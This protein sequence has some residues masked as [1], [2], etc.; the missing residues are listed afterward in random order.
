MKKSCVVLLILSLIFTSLYSQPIQQQMIRVELSPQKSDWLYE[1]GE[2]V[3]ITA[4]IIKNNVPLTENV[5][6]VFNYGKERMKYKTELVHVENGICKINIGT[7]KEPGFL[8]CVASLKYN[9]HDYQGMVTV[10]F[11]PNSIKPTVIKPNDFDDFWA[12]AI[13]VNNI[14]LDLKKEYVVDLSTAK[15]DVYHISFANYRANS[16]IYGWLAIP[17]FE[18]KCPAILRLPGAGVWKS[19]P[20]I[21]TAERGAIVLSIGIH[22]L[23]L[24]Y[25][26]SLYEN[27]KNNALYGYSK[28]GIEDK[29]KNYYKRVFLGCVKALDVFYE[30][31]SFDKKNIGVFGNSQGGALSIVTAA[32]DRRVTACAAIHPALGDL[33][34]Y[35]HDRAGGW[36]H[37]FETI[38]IDDTLTGVYEK[39][40]S[41]YDMVNFARN[42]NIPFYMTWGYNDITC[43]PTSVYCVANIVGKEKTY[44]IVPE[45][46]HWFYQEQMDKL[47][48]WLFKHLNN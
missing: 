23:P 9:N 20:D 8:R 29:N 12:E 2:S 44:D 19:G 17:K 47:V 37:I 18:K 35:L 31:A 40:L 27:L 48:S 7:L 34:G 45:T 6:I 24:T 25:N 41:Y 16:R 28:Y 38:S 39:A 32:L 4:R 36:P 1:V 14:P 42:I 21:S 15:V 43:P 46:G 30:I 5:D 33:T 22:G 13:D 3:E 11:S 26:N 10:G